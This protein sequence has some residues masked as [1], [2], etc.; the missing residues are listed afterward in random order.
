M[1]KEPIWDEDVDDADSQSDPVREDVA[2]DHVVV[3]EV[4]PEHMEKKGAEVPPEG[5]VVQ[6]IHYL[7]VQLRGDHGRG[8]VHPTEEVLVEEVVQKQ[9]DQRDEDDDGDSG[10]K[11]S[12]QPDGLEKEGIVLVEQY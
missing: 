6:Q 2:E 7:K 3:D 9:A 12:G 11:E 1:Y 5:S 10:S 4:G 8:L